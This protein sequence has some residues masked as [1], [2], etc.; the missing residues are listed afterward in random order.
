VIVGSIVPRVVAAAMLAAVLVACGDVEPRVAGDGGEPTA[1]DAD[2]RDAEAADRIDDADGD[3]P[4]GDDGL[5]P[6]P[7]P[8]PAFVLSDAEVLPNAKRLASDVVQD[9][10]TYGPGSTPEEV[11]AQVADG[12]LRATIAATLAPIHHAGAWSRGAVL[13][14]QLGGESGA[15]ASVM[16]VVDQTIG[17]GDGEVRTERRTFDVRLRVV[18][19]VWELDAI[20]SVGGVPVPRPDQLSPA[21]EAVLDDERIDLPDTARWDIHAGRTADS[22]LELMAELAELTPYGVIVLETGH[23]Y[24]VFGTPRVSRHIAGFAVDVHRLGDV[25]VVDDR[26]DD[27]ATYRLVRDLY[28]RDDVRV[29]GSPWALDGFGGRS[30]TDT[31]HQD[32]LHVESI[33]TRREVE[34]AQERGVLR[35]EDELEGTG[36]ATRDDDG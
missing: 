27:G 33:P 10:T 3:G 16:V 31:V 14:P 13:Y 15:R 19:G 6:A 1:P 18:G 2:E 22:L 29:I 24:N 34:R 17:T 32:H 28:E 11:A 8:A 23:P 20:A 5:P 9:L 12:P 26:D 21:A 25:L 7:D 36:E 35:G 4:N 30:F